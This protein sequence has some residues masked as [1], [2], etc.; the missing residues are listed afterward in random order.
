MNISD[1]LNF[2]EFIN[3]DVLARLIM[4]EE[5]TFKTTFD[6]NQNNRDLNI[7]CSEHGIFL[8]I[9]LRINSVEE[10]RLSNRLRYYVNKLN[11]TAL[12]NYR[13][14]G[15][16]AIFN[17]HFKTYVDFISFYKKYLI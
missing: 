7:S 13:K 12:N 16:E 5:F 14:N 9:R 10:K 8:T 3:N 17:L 2:A 15:Y 6:I 1:T 11:L 4:N